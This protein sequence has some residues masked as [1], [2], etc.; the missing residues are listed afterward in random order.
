MCVLR[1]NLKHATTILISVL[2]FVQM[3]INSNLLG[4]LII[5]LSLT[6]VSDEIMLFPSLFFSSILNEN[7]FL[8]SSMTASRYFTILIILVSVV[9]HYG[10]A[11]NRE[12]VKLLIYLL[13]F[14]FYVI[15]SSV[16]S[17]SIDS[18]TITMI[19]N[20]LVVYAFAIQKPDD[21]SLKF[22][23]FTTCFICFI[24]IAYFCFIYL[25]NGLG[26]NSYGSIDFLEGTNKNYVGMGL[27]QI[28]AFS[29]SI[30]LISSTSK[31][32]KTINLGMVAG[33]SLL[34][35]LSGA[36]AALVGLLTCFTAGIIL[37]CFK[38]RYKFRRAL[39]FILVLYIGAYVSSLII[40]SIPSLAYRFSLDTI[41]KTGGTGRLPIWEI[42]WKHAFLKNPIFGVG[43][44][45]E[46]IVD[47][48]Y[49]Y[50]ENHSGTHNMFLDILGQTGL[51]GF[52]Y[53]FV[54]LFWKI[55]QSI[56]LDITNG[57][58]ITPILLIACCIGNGIGENIWT[59]RFTWVAISLL[60]Y[61]IS[62]QNNRKDNVFWEEVI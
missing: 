27:A 8:F 61:T 5:L 52:I 4:L 29:F 15:L 55:K 2:L 16:V 14:G 60:I 9:H 3:I 28:G 57:Y 43:F 48:L 33:T 22:A 37:L 40:Q 1:I 19:L 21:D 53:L 25:M 44:G 47:I 30:C 62:S 49:A 45:G 26:F 59:E 11:R 42:V 13:V 12:N 17:S 31:F 51:F 36:K 54:G 58:S 20:L 50:G 24:L 41:I 10:R 34:I 23:I 35:I 7:C 46:N 18:S 6:L 39:V 56:K 32:I 38:G